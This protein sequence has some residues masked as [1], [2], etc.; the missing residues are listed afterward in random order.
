MHNSRLKYPRTKR[1]DQQSCSESTVN[2]EAEI[3]TVIRSSFDSTSGHCA[4]RFRGTQPPVPRAA[5]I[6]EM[7]PNKSA[8]R[9]QLRKWV[10][11]LPVARA[12]LRK[13]DTGNG[14]RSSPFGFWRLADGCWLLAIRASLFAFTSRLYLLSSSLFAFACESSIGEGSALW[15]GSEKEPAELGTQ[16]K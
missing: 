9:K 11:G 8:R 16:R 4:R 15:I 3:H 7:K 14:G 5:Q 2:S 12:L 1:F 6:S 10:P 13:Y